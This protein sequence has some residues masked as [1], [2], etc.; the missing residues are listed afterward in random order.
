MSLKNIRITNVKMKEVKLNRN[1]ENI[2]SIYLMSLECLE[3]KYSSL[4]L[5]K[6]IAKLFLYYLQIN[7]I[8]NLQDL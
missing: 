2:L 8:L 4:H 3:L 6:Y 5:R 1:Y 7:N